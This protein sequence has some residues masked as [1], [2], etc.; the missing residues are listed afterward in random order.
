MKKKIFFITAIITVIL[1]LSGFYIYSKDP[2][3]FKL[4]YEVYNNIKFSNGKIIKTSIPFDNKVKYVDIKEIKEILTKKTGVVYFGYPT[5]QWCRNIVPV[6][7]DTVNNSKLDTLY[8]VNVE[9]VNTKEIKTILDPFLKFNS[10][11]EKQL[12]VPDVYF[13]KDGKILDHHIGVVD[14]YKDAFLGMN[15]EQKQKLSEIYQA[16]INKILGD[17][18]NER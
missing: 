13:I 1:I 2:Y 4:E 6:L 16:G 7:V 5:C 14:D 18:S 11:G 10:E 3:R 17:D 9:E 15:K 12:Y 8:Y